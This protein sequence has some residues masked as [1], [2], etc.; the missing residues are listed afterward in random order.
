MIEILRLH[1]R[2]NRDHR[3]STHLALT[4]RTLSVDKFYYAG[5]RDKKFEES[6][7]N[8]TR[9]FGGPFEVEHIDNPIKLI[10]EKK[11]QGYTIIHLT[12]YGEA[13]DKPKLKSKKLLIIVGGEKVEPEYYHIADYN[14][15]VGNQP[16]SELGALAIFLHKHSKIKKSFKDA[17]ITILP[18][19]KGKLIKDIKSK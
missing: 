14:L 1:H 16:H 6:V 4:S 5:Q 18:S 8:I 19:A 2:V 15:A 13:F 17:K 3:I 7:N 12:M 9:R 11:K 10:K